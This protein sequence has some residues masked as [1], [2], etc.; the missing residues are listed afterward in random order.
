LASSMLI[1]P[2]LPKMCRRTDASAH[3]AF[4]TPSFHKKSGLFARLSAL[5][6]ERAVATSSTVKNLPSL[7]KDK[8]LLKRCWL[9][10]SCWLSFF[11]YFCNFLSEIIIPMEKY[12]LKSNCRFW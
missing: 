4:S 11:R 5:K 9:N 3:T 1:F 2:C 7:E 8:N 10:L 6:Y 12:F